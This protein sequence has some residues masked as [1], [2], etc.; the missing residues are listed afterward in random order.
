MI[1]TGTAVNRIK[2]FNGSSEFRMQESYDLGGL[3]VR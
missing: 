3:L 2:F 1:K